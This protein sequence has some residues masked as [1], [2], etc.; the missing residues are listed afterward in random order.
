M[1]LL[2]R[3]LA[4]ALLACGVSLAF[5]Q[6]QGGADDDDDDDDAPAAAASGPALAHASQPKPDLPLQDL[7]SQLLYDFLLGEIAAQRD[8]ASF[9]AQT[10][11]DLARRTRDPRVARRA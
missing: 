4:A 9:A 11:V 2:Y 5:A 10:Y 8:S 3:F 7:S 1:P 6:A